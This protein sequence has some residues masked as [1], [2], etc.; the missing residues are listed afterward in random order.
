MFIASNQYNDEIN[1][2]KILCL[3]LTVED[4]LDMQNLGWWISFEG[5]F[6]ITTYAK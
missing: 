5:T 6:N 2:W 1:W 3:N 4:L